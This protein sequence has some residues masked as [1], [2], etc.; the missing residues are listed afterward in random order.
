MSIADF[1]QGRDKE[2][3]CSNCYDCA[4]TRHCVIWRKAEMAYDNHEKEQKEV[5]KKYD[6]WGVVVDMPEERTNKA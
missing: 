6:S 1:I 4:C 2:E 5:R 3:F